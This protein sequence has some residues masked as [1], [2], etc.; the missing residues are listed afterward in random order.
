VLSQQ[1]AE[2]SAE[3]QSCH[4]DSGVAAQSR[5]Q[6]APLRSTVQLAGARAGLHMGGPPLG[7]DSDGLQGRQVD[8][9]AIADGGA[10]HVVST[11]TDRNFQ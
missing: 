6:T 8:Y 9:H 5:G 11:R 1:P 4:T 7:I 3:R 2:T 10:E